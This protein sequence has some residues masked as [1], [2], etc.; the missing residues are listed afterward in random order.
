LL[1]ATKFV[2]GCSAGNMLFPGFHR[3]FFSADICLPGVKTSEGLQTGAWLY[4]VNAKQVYGQQRLIGY[5]QRPV[6][7]S[8]PDEAQCQTV[9]GES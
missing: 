7:Q 1:L 3:L 4:L 5:R 8:R 6:P 2:E 9:V